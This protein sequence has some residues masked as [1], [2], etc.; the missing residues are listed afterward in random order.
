MMLKSEFYP[1]WEN[2]LCGIQDSLFLTC[3]IFPGVNKSIPA[4]WGHVLFST[5]SK[6]DLKM[7][8][9]LKILW[10]WEASVNFFGNTRLLL[11][12]LSCELGNGIQPVEQFPENWFCFSRTTCWQW[13]LCK[14]QLK[15]LLPSLFGSKLTNK[16]RQ[17]PLSWYNSAFSSSQAN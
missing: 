6:N 2:R 11:M 4:Y 8:L 1:L 10:K 5:P 15:R 9:D 7:F 3:P 16:Q 17:S 14:L 13:A 12:S